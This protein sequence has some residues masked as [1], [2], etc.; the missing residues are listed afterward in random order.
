MSPALVG[1]KKEEK[2]RNCIIIIDIQKKDK[3]GMRE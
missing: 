3:K 1:R 2:K